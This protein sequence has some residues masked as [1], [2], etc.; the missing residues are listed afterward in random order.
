MLRFVISGQKK[1]RNLTKI[2]TYK[3]ITLQFFAFVLGNY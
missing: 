2:V 1:T 3:Q